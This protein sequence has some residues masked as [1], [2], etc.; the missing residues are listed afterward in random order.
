[1]KLIKAFLI[2]AILLG[3]VLN[4]CEAHFQNI[5]IETITDDNGN[6]SNNL[7]I[8]FLVVILN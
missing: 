2:F 3:C 4:K 5:E 6:Q 7:L 1:M 8:V